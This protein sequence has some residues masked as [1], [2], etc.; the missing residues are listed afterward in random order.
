MKSNKPP[1][2]PSNLLINNIQATE[3]TV[4]WQDNS[5][6]ESQFEIQLS[7]ADSLNFIEVLIVSKNITSTTVDEVKPETLYFCRVR[8]INNGGNSDFTAAV[9]FTTKSILPLPPENLQF[10]FLPTREVK[11]FWENNEPKQAAVIIERSQ[12][13]NKEFEQ[14]GITAIGD[15][16]YT[17][18]D[19]DAGVQYFYRVAAFNGT[20]NSEYSNEIFVSSSITSIENDLLKEL[21]IYPN[22]VQEYLFIEKSNSVSAINNI[23]ITDITGKIMLKKTL[24]NSND[25]ERIKID[26]TTL[27]N[28]MYILI[29][30]DVASKKFI[31]Q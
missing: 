21:I 12:G 22:P 9:P 4:S 25:Y 23:Q 5:E 8:A 7:E 11:L 30:N 18:A 1:K 20:N 28:G 19:F 14:I 13:S 27:P 24:A 10:V 3:F 2:K 16:T 6:N 29:I 31:K 17:D 26:T 15:S